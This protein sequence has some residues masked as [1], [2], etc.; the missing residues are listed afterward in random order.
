M[1][2]PQ[3]FEIQATIPEQLIDF[4]QGVF[5]WTFQKQEGTSSEYW[6]ITTEGI[7]GGL[8][9]RPPETS[10][11]SS[12]SGTNAFT[13]SMEV[14]NFDD[15]AAKIETMGGQVFLEKFAV[16]GKCWQGYFL[17]PEGNVFG[18]FVPDPAAN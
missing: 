9:L 3:Y 17:D 13:V 14:K 5:M 12:N 8:M 15:T 2:Q 11:P 10:A 18:I 7:S 6:A 4:Y 1:N 16:P